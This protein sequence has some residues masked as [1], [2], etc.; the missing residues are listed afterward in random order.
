ML[1]LSFNFNLVKVVSRI[2]E[3]G[4]HPSSYVQ[5]FLCF[6]S[7]MIIKLVF[8]FSI[9]FCCVQHSPASF[10]IFIIFYINLKMEDLHNRRKELEQGVQGLRVRKADLQHRIEQ[11][12][13]QSLSTSDGEV[14][15]NLIFERGQLEIELVQ[16]DLEF[17]NLRSQL[18]KLWLDIYQKRSR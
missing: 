17:S 7:H 4:F 6:L 1:I 14:Q 8:S 5:Y 16:V 9:R 2:V 10:K 18:E 11:L 3:S 15:R 13:N 12:K